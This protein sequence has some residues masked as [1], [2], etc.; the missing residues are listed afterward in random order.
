MLAQETLQAVC[1]LVT[2]APKQPWITVYS[3]ADIRV[4][5]IAR[6][7]YWESVRMQKEAVNRAVFEVW[8]GVSELDEGVVAGRN[9]IA[10]ARLETARLGRLLQPLARSGKTRLSGSREG[11][12]GSGRRRLPVPLVRFGILSDSSVVPRK[13]GDRNQW[14]SL[15]RKTGLLC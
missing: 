9:A 3:W 15:Q 12:P 13:R 14:R 5:S 10:E 11:R 7:V 4:H 1:P 8:R 6:Q 2:P